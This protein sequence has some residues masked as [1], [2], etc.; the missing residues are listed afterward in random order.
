MLKLFDYLRKIVE[1]FFFFLM[2]FETFHYMEIFVY[3]D[4]ANF[5]Q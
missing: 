4:S 2:T 3:D 1:I 5:H